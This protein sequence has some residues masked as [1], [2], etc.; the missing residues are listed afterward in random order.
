[1]A[2]TYTD[3]TGQIWHRFTCSYPIDDTEFVFHIYA[4]DWKDAERRIA[5]IGSGGRVDGQ[6]VKEMDE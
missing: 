3:Y 2:H 6:L 4:L 5:A 1:M